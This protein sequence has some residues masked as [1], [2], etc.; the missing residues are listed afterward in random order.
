MLA[1]LGMCS[2]ALWELQESALPY[3]LVRHPLYGGLVLSFGWAVG[4]GQVYKLVQAIALFA[5]LVSGAS[6]CVGAV[7]FS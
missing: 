5:V 4:Q 6:V 3:S 2:N 7:I 1:G